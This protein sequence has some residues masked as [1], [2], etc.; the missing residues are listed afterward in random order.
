[1]PRVTDVYAALPSITG[2]FELEYEGELSGAEPV[3]R[4]IIRSA[5]ANVFD[6]YSPNGDRH[7]RSSSG[8]TAAARCS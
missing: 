1:M 6:G 7:R 4:E 3:A 5:V 2:K 8:S